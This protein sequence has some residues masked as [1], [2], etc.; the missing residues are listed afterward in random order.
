M[1]AP[2]APVLSGLQHAAE[3]GARG[4]DHGPGGNLGAVGEKNPPHPAVF[5]VQPRNFAFDHLETG[6]S[7]DDTPNRVASRPPCHTVPEAPRP[8]GPGRD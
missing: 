4:Q 6:K 5:D 7:L 1:P 2:G 8:P 3:E